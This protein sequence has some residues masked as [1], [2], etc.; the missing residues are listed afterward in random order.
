[1]A[2]AVM[3]AALA[4]VA[5]SAVTVELAAV[6]SV[7]MQPVALAGTQVALAAT[8][9]LAR[10]NL[11]AIT[12]DMVSRAIGTAE[13]GTAGTGVAVIGMAAGVDGVTR[14]AGITATIVTTPMAIIIRPRAMAPV[15]L[16]AMATRRRAP[17]S[18]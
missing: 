1:M 4:A 12:G 7:L 17:Q 9:L 8:V 11:A 18:S 10:T 3:V 13:A 2:V 15:M 14:T 16:M 6:V 5:A